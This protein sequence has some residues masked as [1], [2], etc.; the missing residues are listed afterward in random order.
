MSIIRS[1]I[2]TV[3]A[4]A[5]FGAA[6]TAEA[7]PLWRGDSWLV[8]DDGDS[9][10]ISTGINAWRYHDET[11]RMYAGFAAKGEYVIAAV[12]IRDPDLI[13][14]TTVRVYTIEG[15]YLTSKAACQ[16]GYGST[17]MNWAYDEGYPTRVTMQVYEVSDLLYQ[18]TQTGGR[19]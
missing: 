6:P 16:R 1:L 7:S 11:H 2:G 15:K 17:R 5:G 3:A 8:R 14:C 12:K 13:V 10:G 19:T 4:I 18:R 9:G